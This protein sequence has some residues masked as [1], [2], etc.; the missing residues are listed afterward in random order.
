MTARQRLAVR[1][2]GA[3]E[4]LEDLGQE[5]TRHAQVCGD[6]VARDHS[7]STLAGQKHEDREPV[8]ALARQSHRPLDLC[9]FRFAMRN[10]NKNAEVSD[11]FRRSLRTND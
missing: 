4:L 7:V 5:V 11:K 10:V 8:V 3:G 1:E 9:I 6:L 2:T